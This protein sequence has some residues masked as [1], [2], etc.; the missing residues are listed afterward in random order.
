MMKAKTYKPTYLVCPTCGGETD[1]NI[2]EAVRSKLFQFN[3][4]CDCCGQRMVLN[5]SGE[6]E[7]SYRLAGQV[8]TSWNL[9]YLP[10]MLETPLFLVAENPVTVQE[11]AEVS[12]FAIERATS[13][14]FLTQP[15]NSPKLVCKIVGMHALRDGPLAHERTI[16]DRK[17]L[18]FD[19]KGYLSVPD[20]FPEV[21][22]M[23]SLIQSTGQGLPAVKH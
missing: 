23:I 9:I 2:T 17:A 5:V 7:V 6:S 3:A 18:V 11:N 10:A 1:I 22:D 13:G 16:S 19:D 15:Y 8:I 14:S 4:T 20:T 12:E 21:R